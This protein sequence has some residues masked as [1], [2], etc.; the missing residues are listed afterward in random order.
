[1]VEWSDGYVTSID[2]TSGFYPGLSP[3]SQNFS[4]LLRGIAPVELTDGFSYCELGCGHGF[5]T[6][7][8]AA[9]NPTGS[10]WGVDFNPAH[11]SSAERLAAAARVENVTFLDQSFAEAL[12]ASLPRLDFIALHGV[13]SWISGENRRAI[14][15]FI[16]AKLKPGGV[17]YISYNALPGWAAHAPLR[18]LLVERLR[19]KTDITPEAINE[20]VGFA[21]R[22]RETGAAYFAANPHSAQRLEAIATSSRNYVAHEYFNRHWSPS[23][24]SD[25]AADLSAAKLVFGAPSEVAEH[26]DQRLLKPA[27]QEL[28]KELTDS[29]ARETV[30]DYYLNRQ[31]R[32]D[33]FVRG[34]RELSA[35]EREERLLATRFAVIAPQPTYPFKLRFPLGEVTFEQSPYEAILNALAE[36]PLTLGE[37]LSKTDVGALGSQAVFQAIILSIAARLVAPTLDPEGE[38][39]RRKST[40]RFNEA[41][42]SQLGG[43][44]QEQTLAS[45]ILG[46]GIPVP[47]IHQVFLATKATDA[48]LPIDTVVAAITARHQQLR[49][50]GKPVTSLEE[51]RSELQQ[52][53]T[54]FRQSRFPIYQRLGL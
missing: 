38:A 30:I 22:V 41:V 32:R 44:R 7:L 27:A 36:Q 12:T 6:T 14:I 28:L 10:F 2:Y 13:W 45:P 35:R 54:E 16:Y 9:A 34:A 46:T 42:L 19:G 39:E 40:A 15:D 47:Q 50:K 23:Y 48:R 52:A 24:H 8:L 3:L 11:V 26:V 5:S 43:D 33:L 37:L 53:L 17:I 18:Q 49:K 31:F 4:L 25:V 21:A 29:S 20:A 1:M 51:T